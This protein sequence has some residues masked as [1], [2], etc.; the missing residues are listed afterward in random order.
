MANMQQKERETIVCKSMMVTDTTI[1]FDA[2]V[3][4]EKQGSG[5][6]FIADDSHAPFGIKDKRKD[7]TTASD[8]N[9]ELS[10]LGR[11]T[12]LASDCETGNFILGNVSTQRIRSCKVTVTFEGDIPDYPWD[13]KELPERIE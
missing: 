5:A 1:T 9:D 13:I 6:L 2:F 4:R 10:D 11:A 8:F 12:L 7:Y 3:I